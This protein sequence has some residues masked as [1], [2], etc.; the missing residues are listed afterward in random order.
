MYKVLKCKRFL[1]QQIGGNGFIICIS[2][3]TARYRNEKKKYILKPVY[4]K[5]SNTPRCYKTYTG[6]LLWTFRNIMLPPS[7]GSRRPNREIG[8]CTARYWKWR[9]LVHPKTSITIDRLTRYSIGR[10]LEASSAPLRWPQ[11]LHP[12]NGIPVILGVRMDGRR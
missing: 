8:S 1:I 7:S 4:A 11:I 9:H 5:D 2:R 10:D 3:T 12:S 6:K